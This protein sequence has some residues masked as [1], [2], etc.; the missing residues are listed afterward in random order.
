[1][2]SHLS[3]WHLGTG[4]AWSRFFGCLLIFFVLLCALSLAESRRYQGFFHTEETGTV[5]WVIR[6]KAQLAAFR[7][8][9]PK[10]KPYKR[11]PAP[12]NDDPLLT[13]AIDFSKEMLLV[14]GRGDTLSA[15]PELVKVESGEKLT[16]T[17]SLPELPPEA[18]PQGLG[19]YSGVVL[20]VTEAE[21]VFLWKQRS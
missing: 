5:T 12:L 11:Q 7:A 17:W 20:P 13:D 8:L 15:R 21:V 1:M 14:A 18:K 4:R 2:N 16:L 6:S 10:T 19:A 3:R 9:I